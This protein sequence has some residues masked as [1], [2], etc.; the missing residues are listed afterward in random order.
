VTALA[1][2][3]LFAALNRGRVTV[4]APLVGTGVVW[5][6]VFAAI[7]LGRSEIVSPRLVL[8][9]LLVVVGSALVGATQ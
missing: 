6:V 3:M 5:T 8:V 4:V 9:A 2:M 7:F 1:Q